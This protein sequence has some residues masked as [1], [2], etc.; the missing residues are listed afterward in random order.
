MGIKTVGK[1]KAKAAGRKPERRLRNW[2]IAPPL[3]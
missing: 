2:L 1:A 3:N